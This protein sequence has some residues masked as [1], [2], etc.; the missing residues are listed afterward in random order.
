MGT[1]KAT[2]RPPSPRP[3]TDKAP[4]ISAT[5]GGAVAPAIRQRDLDSDHPLRQALA[6]LQLA[7][8]PTSVRELAAR[9]TEQHPRPERSWKWQHAEAYRLV[10]S[11]V[12]SISRGRA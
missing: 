5:A 9:V 7:A 2:R 3:A 6:T 1:G 4:A 8:M 10:F 11:A 12:C